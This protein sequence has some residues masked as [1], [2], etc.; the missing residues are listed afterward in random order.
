MMPNGRNAATC[1]KDVIQVT[2]PA[3]G[4]FA[5][6]VAAGCSPTEDAFDPPPHPI[7]RLRFL[8]PDRL[9]DPDQHAGIDIG[10]RHVSDRGVDVGFEGGSPLLGMLGVLPAGAVGIDVGVSLLPKRHR[11]DHSRARLRPL[12]G[13]LL[14]GVGSPAA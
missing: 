12:G 10:N 3:R 1:R 9:Q 7:R 14:D 2:T 6:A 13:A 11:L 5:R 4:V 8:G